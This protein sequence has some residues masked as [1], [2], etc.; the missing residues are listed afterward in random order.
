MIIEDVVYDYTKIRLL[1]TETDGPGKKYKHLEN[2]VEQ[3]KIAI[4]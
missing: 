1:K 2:L 4:K 3:T